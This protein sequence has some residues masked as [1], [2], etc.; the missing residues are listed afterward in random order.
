MLQQY[1]AD[2]VLLIHFAFILFVL[3]GGLV[4]WRWHWL[5]WLHLPAVGWAALIEL[6]GWICPLTP[7]ENRLRGAAGASGYS[8]GF[9]EH[10]LLA[11]IYPRGLSR[12]LHIALGVLVLLLNLLIYLL[13]WMSRRRRRLSP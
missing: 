6:G 4:V 11:A 8:G 1:A 2:A 13:L 3:A 7:L 10:Y 5:A 12:E 9:V